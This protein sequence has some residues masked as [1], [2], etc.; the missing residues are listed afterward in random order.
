M[1][2]GRDGLSPI[3]HLS[4]VQHKD[5]RGEKNS[6]N[7][8]NY[9]V[10]NPTVLLK[11]GG[12]LM[13]SFHYICITFFLVLLIA[14]Q[15]AIAH[16]IKIPHWVEFVCTPLEPGDYGYPGCS[17]GSYIRWE[18]IEGATSYYVEDLVAGYDTSYAHPTDRRGLG[19]C[20]P[21]GV[22]PSDA[23]C[24]TYQQ[25]KFDE[26]YSSTNSRY[27]VFATFPDEDGN[28]E[29]TKKAD[30]TGIVYPGDIINYTFTYKNTGSGSLSDAEIIETLPA[31]VELISGGSSHVGKEVRWNLGTLSPGQHGTVSMQVKID[32][33]LPP[34]IDRIYNVAVTHLGGTSGTVGLGIGL[35]DSFIAQVVHGDVEWA[36]YP[37]PTYKNVIHKDNILGED[38]VRA[39][40]GLATF[41]HT[42]VGG[43][44]TLSQG[45][46]KS[47]LCNLLDYPVI[48]ELSLDN[49]SN[50]QHSVSGIL[51]ADEHV[52]VHSN[53]LTL[54]IHD[55]DYALDS[56]GGVETVRVT[57]G[58]VTVTDPDS[59]IHVVLA[60][61][62]FSWPTPPAA[63][64][65]RITGTT[66]ENLQSL[67]YEHFAITYSF[68][69]EVTS[70][71]G[72][73]LFLYSMACNMYTFNGTLDSLATDVS[74]SWNSANTELTIT[75]N[76]SNPYR[77]GYRYRACEVTVT[78]KFLDV[79][80]ASGT[81]A[82]L[83]KSVHLFNTRKTTGTGTMSES[84]FFN[85]VAIS[86]GTGG[87][88]D[89]YA[90]YTL[91]VVDPPGALPIGMRLLSPV[92]NVHFDGSINNAYQVALKGTS[93]TRMKNCAIGG[94]VY[95]WQNT[96]WEQLSEGIGSDWTSA[97][98]TESNVYVAMLAKSDDP[99]VP[100]ILSVSHTSPTDQ[101]T[102]ANPL[103]IQVKNP[104]GLDL[105]QTDIVVGGERIWA[106][107]PA[108]GGYPNWTVSYSG[109]VATLTYTPPAGWSH[110]SPL[111]G[112][113]NVAGC[114]GSL[115]A[116]VNIGQTTTNHFPW[117]MVLPAIIINR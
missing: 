33:N 43:V 103:V 96:S 11:G 109:D 84:T 89:N 68:D 2:A 51:N 71:S 64:G 86:G 113:I 36:E 16:Q 22:V 107:N 110:A 65:P 42:I 44:L 59:D 57:R 79:I 23:G 77:V 47:K 62:S 104:F 75:V 117:I 6:R 29:V 114:Y 9:H 116:L 82:S 31:Y 80:G 49:A 1:D 72:D 102:P 73:S 92:Y 69:Q 4:P 101:I 7:C 25:L 21:C 35:C 8:S 112:Y 74:S 60:G 88:F 5:Q 105:H 97:D 99:D 53:Y 28:L 100:E 26:N 93:P 40:T 63:T 115:P 41:D 30:V 45:G 90:S 27:Q 85:N 61:Y 81:S 70:L 83:L 111:Y 14:P 108:Q 15:G 24:C 48:S 46:F 91:Q 17:A 20:G 95:A 66:P 76:N 13:R 39:N 12:T 50:V 38:H 106:Y 19:G 94:G 18:P 56:S 98:V 67:D 52:L 10:G 37:D 3:T 54:N 78:T 87:T 58:Q 55:G 32:K 34:S